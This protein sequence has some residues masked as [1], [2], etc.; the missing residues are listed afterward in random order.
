MQRS[1]ADWRRELRAR[2][3][4][5]TAIEARTCARHAAGSLAASSL[6]RDALN[7]ALYIPADG[8]L[9]TDAIAARARRD[10]KSLYLPVVDGDML[11]FREWREG[12]ALHPNRFGIGEPGPDASLPPEL[13]LM[14]LPVVGW[15]AAG[16]R[17]GMGGG[18]Y[19]RYLARYGTAG[20]R[21][22]GLAYEQQREEHLEALR[23]PFDQGL[24][25]VLTERRLYVL[26]GTA[27]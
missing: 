6:W 23:E 1:K 25:A 10:G 8:E 21:R 20:L 18:F 17:L 24:D 27:G 14:L 16:F 13:Q 5:I 4:S 26:R 12:A 19:D 3:G 11:Q 22:V 15:T 7:I 2:R 9:P